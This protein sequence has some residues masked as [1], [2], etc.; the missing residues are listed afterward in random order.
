[1][2]PDWWENHLVFNWG[3][4]LILSQAESQ[5]MPFETCQIV[6]PTNK[7]ITL[8]ILTG[9]CACLH[10]FSLIFTAVAFEIMHAELMQ[11]PV[12]RQQ[13]DKSSR[14]VLIQAV[15]IVTSSASCWMPSAV[16]HIISLAMV[17]YP[18][19]ILTW[20]AVLVMPFTS[21]FNTIIY[22]I[23]PL[24]KKYVP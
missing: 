12:T 15:L 2:L 23:Y 9:L 17:T 8:S 13:N 5:P 1:M 24:A 20:N 4:L 18:T 11:R 16:F 21:V 6:C 19:A 3:S 7:S 14:N 10:I 22:T